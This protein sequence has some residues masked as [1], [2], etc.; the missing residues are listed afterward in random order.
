M[1]DD[2]PKRK[3]NTAGKHH[4][5]HG[6]NGHN[7]AHH[8]KPGQAHHDHGHKHAHHHGHGHGHGHGEHD[9]HH[10]FNAALGLIWG[11]GML[12][13][14]IGSFNIPMLGY[15]AITASTALVT[16]YLGSTVYQNA[17]N[18]LKANELDI[19]ILY[20]ISTL[21]ILA[22]SV[23]SIFVP[24]L[25][26]MFEAAPLVLG[27]WHLGE[28]IEHSLIEQIDEKLDIRD[29]IDPYVICRGKR[30]PVLIETLVAGNIIHVKNR[31]NSHEEVYIPVD[32]ELITAA[33]LYTTQINGSPE[34]QWFA[35]GSTVKSGMRLAH[36]LTELHMKV[37]KTYENSYLSQVARKANQA[38]EKMAPVELLTT[39]VLRYFIPGLLAV[40]ALSGIVIGCVYGPALA[41]QCVISVLVSACPCALSLI[42]PMAVKIGMKKA[43][44]NG[45]QFKDGEALQASA[46]VDVVVF[47]LNGTLTQGKV[48]VGRLDIADRELLSH[49]ALLE[50]Q[51]RRKTQLAQAI[52]TRIKGEGF[53]IAPPLSIQSVEE[54]HNGIKGV[55][56]GVRLMI[57]DK[58][59]LTHNGITINAPYDNLE[60]GTIYIVRDEAVIG[61]VVLTD[62]LRDDAIK[63]VQQLRSLGKEIHICTGADKD[64][65]KKYAKELGISEEYIW[66][67]T[68]AG[69]P[70]PGEVT[71]RTV[72]LNLKRKG[73]KVAMVGD[74][75]NDVEALAVADVGVAVKSPIGSS[76]IEKYASILVQK[77][78]LFPIATAFDIGQ[79][80]KDNIYQNLFVSLAYN[81][82]I[83][84]AAAGV[85][86]GLGLTLNPV[87][88]TVFMI[89]ESTIVLTNLYRFK[90]QEVVAASVVCTNAAC[91]EPGSLDSAARMLNALG[92]RQQA[93]AAKEADPQIY[94]NPLSAPSSVIENTTQ[95]VCVP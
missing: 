80:A 89:L 28:G 44:E 51:A 62:P 66:A 36:P 56:G 41:I 78:L 60:N 16:W 20:S 26:M 7:H 47:D 88:G 65:A 19:S 34:V 29:C 82:T 3:N 79:K 69:D 83:T 42:T 68:V 37:T 23:V 27:F 49:I 90:Q 32:G 54:S 38:S 81:S 76:S 53:A 63:T 73:H 55:I 9:E 17:W 35:A 33:W 84:L 30:N 95:S 74:S 1:I 2:K 15:Y 64:T 10:W 21:T 4:V 94:P 40:A 77:G 18:A 50:S 39:Q 75:I 46:D 86:I 13:L 5:G 85:F 57:G 43:S 87:L 45:I 11:V 12:V 52:I 6:H 92:P 71:K 48:E 91:E 72:I 25:P 31:E 59:M 70:K 14:A 24:G 22:V 61:Q 8:G 93:V 58:A 67:N